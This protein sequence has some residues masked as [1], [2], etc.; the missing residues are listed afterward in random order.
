MSDLADQLVASVSKQQPTAFKTNIVHSE[1][2]PLFERLCFLV[3]SINQQRKPHYNHTHEYTY[4]ILFARMNITSIP[5]T[6]NNK[7]LMQMFVYVYICIYIYKYI[8]SW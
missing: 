7:Q 4:I 6:K 2:G 1:R 3:Q 8:Y 5:Q